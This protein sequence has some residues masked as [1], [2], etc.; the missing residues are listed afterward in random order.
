MS[1]PIMIR[2]E[3][4]PVIVHRECNYELSEANEPFPNGCKGCGA[5]PC[6]YHCDD[7]DYIAAK[8][9]IFPPSIPVAPCPQGQQPNLN[10]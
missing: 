4:F 1:S 5:G 2:N 9:E 8:G 3:V 7:P 10:V 6:K